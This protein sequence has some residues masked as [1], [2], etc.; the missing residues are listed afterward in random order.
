METRKC[1]Q[2][3]SYDV[4]ELLLVWNRVN[5]ER[6]IPQGEVHLAELYGDVYWCDR[7][8]GHVERPIERG[9]QHGQAT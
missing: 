4:Q 6:I 9:E 3:G 1:P 8:D 2:C 7:C 5:D